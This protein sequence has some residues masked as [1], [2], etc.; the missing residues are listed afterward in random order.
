MDGITLRDLILRL[1]AENEN[2]DTGKYLEDTL[3]AE[4]T[5]APL[6]DVQ[7]QIR[8]LEDHGLL[9]VAA[10]FGPSYGVR[11]TPSGEAALER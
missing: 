11:L 9:D 1:A 7:R 2:P 8:I 4:R 3:L 5:G 6:A 10:G